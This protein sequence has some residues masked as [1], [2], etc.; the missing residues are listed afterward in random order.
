VC[1]N[2]NYHG[3]TEKAECACLP[4]LQGAS[5]QLLVMGS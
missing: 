5:G 4:Q 2:V 3:D 1:G